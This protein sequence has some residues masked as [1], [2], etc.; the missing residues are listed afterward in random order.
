MIMMQDLIYE[1]N[2]F[3]L[4]ARYALFDTDDYDNRQYVFE[5]DV[6]LAYTFP[7]WQDKGIRSY[8]LLEYKFSRAFTLWLRMAHTTYINRTAIGSGPDRISGP[9]RS[10]IRL[11]LRLRF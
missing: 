4:T 5:N 7:A 2:R 1:H 11:Q 9:E 10:D 8:L 6:W 3:S